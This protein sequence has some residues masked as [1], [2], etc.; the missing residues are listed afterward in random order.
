M[1]DK[2]KKPLNEQAVE[3]ALAKEAKEAVLG[4]FGKEEDDFML[5]KLFTTIDLADKLRIKD[6][7]ITVNLKEL[8]EAQQEYL[9][10]MTIEE[11]NDE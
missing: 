9:K 6:F 10:H 8:K 1:A 2:P 7:K 11:E 5:S 3:L 4:I